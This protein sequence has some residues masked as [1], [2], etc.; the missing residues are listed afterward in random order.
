MSKQNPDFGGGPVRDDSC[1]RDDAKEPGAKIQA[2]QDIQEHEPLHLT[3]EE[4]LALYE[5]AL[6]EE[7]WGHQPC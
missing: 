3:P 1:A 5:K 2:P 7:D 4:Q 6:K